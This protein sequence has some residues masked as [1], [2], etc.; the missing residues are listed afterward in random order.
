VIG[1]IGTSIDVSCEAC[2]G[3]GSNH[4][5]WAD[6]TAKGEPSSLPDRGLTVRLDERA[7]A[8]WSIDPA[9]G[10]ASRAKP[11]TTSKE[12][13][14]CARCHSRRSQMTDE[15]I[16]GQP[17]LDGFRPALLTEG[18]YFPD[19][20]IEDEVYVW[21]SLLQ[22]KM[23]QAG[24]TCSDCHDPHAANVR[25]PG[26]G[27]CYQC[28]LADRYATKEHHFHAEGSAGASC[29]E[30]HMPPTDYMVVDPRHDHSF[31]VPRPDQ[32]VTMGTPNACNKCHPDKTPQWA[33]AQVKT[34]YGEPVQ[35]YQQYAT[36]FHAAREQLP[37]VLGCCR[38]SPPMPINPRSPER[39]RC[40]RCV[41]IRTRQRWP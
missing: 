26:D 39:P 18:L 1:R 8:G 29:V 25:A 27:V 13:Q 19:G 4:L 41:P 31:R 23:Y 7:N 22:S 12:I 24:I 28:H 11:R 14:V 9:T 40:R 16:A 15:V 21:G 17:L 32:S 36:A 34:W 5:Q 38:R 6:A 35:G 33:A 30:C 37:G 2:H 3:P 10:K 20:Q